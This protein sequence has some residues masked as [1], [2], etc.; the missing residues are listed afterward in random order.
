MNVRVLTLIVGL[1]GSVLFAADD[2]RLALVLRAHTDFERVVLA[3]APQLRDT[4][5]CIQTQAA[6]IPLAT[7]EE[8]PV[9]QFRKGYCMLAAAT[10]TRDANAYLQ[11]AAAFDQASAAW[12]ARNLA[13]SR[14]RPAEP[15]PSV[16]PVLASIARL[17]AGQGDAKAIPEAVNAHKCNDAL[18]TPQLCDS[19]LQTGREWVGWTALRKDDVFTAAHEIPETSTAWK[20]WVT[21]KRVLLDDRFADAVAAYR[22][23]IEIWEAQTSAGANVPL[24]DRLGPPFDLSVAYTELGGAQ[25]L[26][27]DTSAAIETLNQAL[28]RDSGNARA[29][30]LR[31]RAHDAAGQ[32]DAAIA[33]YNLAARNALAK[34]TDASAG[35]A[36]FYRGIAF[37]R[38]K[39]FTRAEDEFN[40]ALGFEIGDALRADAIAWRRLAGVAGGSCEVGSKYLA[41]ALPAV[42]P[43][44]PRNE[45][46]A[47][48]NAC[49]ATNTAQRNL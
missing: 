28:R 1:S 29:L 47:I 3:P 2:Q 8:A 32:A 14:S 18:T 35:E 13:I 10:L 25:L 42:S 7:A 33:D 36:S 37:Y 16:L 26:A 30:F 43:Y 45:A 5:V 15:V 41:E 49:A 40:S 46:R 19:I 38:R 24:R 48:M 20:S 11:A 4:N 31:G 9:Y 27:G 23:A 21:A 17:K 6:M 44:F 22:R 34:G 12:P 39:E